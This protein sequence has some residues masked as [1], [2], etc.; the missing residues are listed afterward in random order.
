MIKTFKYPDEAEQNG[1][2]GTVLIKFVVDREGNVSS[3]QALSG[4]EELRAEAIRVISKSGK[5]TPAIKNG[6]VVNS[7]KYQQIVFQ[8]SE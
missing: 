7:Y 3:I 4:P 1:I 5:W 2:Y 6:D 8:I